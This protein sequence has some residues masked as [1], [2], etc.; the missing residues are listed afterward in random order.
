MA[1]RPENTTQGYDAGRFVEVRE[2]LLCTACLGVSRDPRFCENEALKASKDKKEVS[3][4]IKD[5]HS[6]G[7]KFVRTS[8]LLL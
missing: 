4:I 6:D 7:Q 3:A 2:D 5:F 1:A 8:N